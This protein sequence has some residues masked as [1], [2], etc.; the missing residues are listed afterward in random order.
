MKL[1]S[2]WICLVVCWMYFVCF[3]ASLWGFRLLACDP[4]CC[5]G[6]FELLVLSFST[7]LPF[8]ACFSYSLV[9]FW[10]S[11]RLN[12]GRAAFLIVAIFVEFSGFL[13]MSRWLLSA[14]VLPVAF[15]R[16]VRRA[17]LSWT[18]FTD[19]PLWSG[20]R[21]V[22]GDHLSCLSISALADNPPWQFHPP[23]D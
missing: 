8:Y 11:L 19:F 6:D 3:Y 10:A 18:C 22:R 7:F 16:L 2:K 4:F 23:S 21:W 15:L 13:T 20:W 17:A 5:S 12:E 1:C 9:P 14:S